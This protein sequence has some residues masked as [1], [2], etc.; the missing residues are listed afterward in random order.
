MSVLFLSIIVLFSALLSVGTK[1][2]DRKASGGGT[3]LFTAI[4]SFAAM[5]FFICTSKDFSFDSAFLIYSI[6]YG[7]SFFATRVFNYLAIATGPASISSLICSYALILPA[8]YGLIFLKEP[9][10]KWFFPGLIFLMVS[11]FLLNKKS[12]DNTMKISPKW[13][14]YV[15]IAFL[16]NGMC[17]IVQKMQQ[18]KFDGAY[19]NEFMI[20]ALFFVCI[21]SI[22]IFLL[23]ERK[24]SLAFIPVKH[25]L[26]WGGM[27]GFVNGATNLLIMILFGKMNAAIMF[28]II[29]VGSLI[30]TYVLFRV[31]YKEKLSKMQLAGF[32]LGTIS[33]LLLNL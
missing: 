24:E 33:I 27:C 16:G 28:P 31:L 12:Q 17:S 8:L 2:F 4:S 19:K 21:G 32:G 6:G 5:I 9:V 26:F 14:L 18:M 10:G 20:V 22:V 23:K 25:S 1:E 15:L 13:G 3:Y 11:I 29:S 30:V 7:I